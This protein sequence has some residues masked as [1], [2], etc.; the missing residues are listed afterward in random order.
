MRSLRRARRGGRRAVGLTPSKSTL[1]LR[2]EDMITLKHV[3]LDNALPDTIL[4]V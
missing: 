2:F 1:G 3:G 4:V